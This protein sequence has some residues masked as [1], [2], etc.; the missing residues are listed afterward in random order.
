VLREFTAQLC[1]HKGAVWRRRDLVVLTW[2]ISYE[3]VVRWGEVRW[4]LLLSSRPDETSV[5]FNRAISQKAAIIILAAVRTRD[6]TYKW[7]VYCMSVTGPCFEC[8]PAYCWGLQSSNVLAYRCMTRNKWKIAFVCRKRGKQPSR[9]IR[10]AAH[11]PEMYRIISTCQEKCL[12]LTFRCLWRNKHLC[13]QHSCASV[14]LLQYRCFINCLKT[15]TSDTVVS[16]KIRAFWDAA[17]WCVLHTSSP[18]WWRHYARMK[19]RCTPRRLNGATSQKAWEH[20]YVSR[21]G[22]WLSYLFTRQYTQLVCEY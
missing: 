17:P 16:L 15:P 20:I 3:S 19:R 22:L 11:P 8:G 6:L 1:N 4:V 14:T 2:D 10:G 7:R 12:P 21:C 18:W 9:V 13:P 5:Y